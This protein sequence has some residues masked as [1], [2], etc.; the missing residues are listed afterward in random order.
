MTG[1]HEEI[2]LPSIGS[3]GFTARLLAHASSH[4][5]LAGWQ[6][7]PSL[8]SVL[9]LALVVRRGGL[10]VD[11]TTSGLTSL[12]DVLMQ[13]TS[14]V[15]GT[16]TA[17][18]DLDEYT[19]VDDVVEALLGTVNRQADEVTPE[20]DP[21]E[22]E[23]PTE[24][25]LGPDVL[26]VTGLEKIP[27]PALIKFCD[28]L[29]KRSIHVS[30]GDGD[31]SECTPMVKHAPFDPLVIWVRGKGCDVPAWVIDHFACGVHV[32]MDDLEPV[33]AGLVDGA[34]V[35][36]EYIAS[37]RA[38][39]PYVHV[40]PPLAVHMSNLLSAV[41]CH[42]SLRAC[43]TQRAVR[44]FPEYVKAHR[45]LSGPFDI[46]AGFSAKVLR[47]QHDEQAQ[48][49]RS[50]TGKGLGGGV[51]GVDSWARQAGE[52]PSLLEG[53]AVDDPY[54]TPGNVEG[55][56]KVLIAHRCRRR[57]PREEVMWLMKGGAGDGLGRTRQA[58][59]VDSILDE[60]LQAV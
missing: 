53:E 52:E 55:V 50:M 23:R 1:E 40:H 56:W 32:D 27:S 31:G 5:A 43:V 7:D 15:F 28:V 39:L 46:P 38:L 8:F 12:A 59:E 13:M 29:T 14:A 42:P 22:Q 4:P 3:R 20:T 34:V 30:R 41:S 16:S 33:P 54:C 18:L 24:H 51:G 57:R 44:A 2:P 58:S 47:Q 36:A 49:T 11:T 19:E 10:V 37:L 35:P 26:V 48:M 21:G 17:R 9:L 6:I 25:R 45:L 60:V